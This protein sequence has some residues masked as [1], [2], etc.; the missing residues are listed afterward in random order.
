MKGSDG[1][2]EERAPGW[3][4]AFDPVTER[5]DHQRST[6]HDGQ[7]D[8]ARGGEERPL[9]A[10]HADDG[11][12]DGVGGNP[13]IVAEHGARSDR[14]GGGPI[15]QRLDREVG[16]CDREAAERALISGGDA[17]DGLAGQ[18]RG[19]VGFTA[20]HRSEALTGGGEH[21]EDK[22]ERPDRYA[23]RVRP[24]RHERDRHAAENNRAPKQLGVGNPGA[25]PEPLGQHGERG[26]EA[27]RG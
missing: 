16:E 10:T 2:A 22:T 14:R 1:A 19:G 24:A 11:A 26:G 20:D 8:A 9:V 6:G 18:E 23:R 25:E 12:T 4:F 13:E 27:L 3:T 15:E 7:H 5:Y 21:A 17:V